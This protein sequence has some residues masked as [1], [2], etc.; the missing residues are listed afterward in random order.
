MNANNLESTRE[1]GGRASAVEATEA[2]HRPARVRRQPSRIR[3]LLFL[4]IPYL[5][6]VLVLVGVEVSTRFWLPHVSTLEAWVQSPEQSSTFSDRKQVRIFEG[7]PVLFWRLKPNLDHVI[8]DFTMVSTNAQGLR[9]EGPTGR[10]AA[11]AIRILCLG[12]SIT[13]GYRVPVVWP[14][15][16]KEYGHDWLP[17]PMLL[18]RRL[19]AANPGRQIE[20]IALAV[21]GYTSYQGLAWLRRDIEELKPDVVTACFGWNDV[22]MRAQTD[23]QTM[24]NGWAQVILRRAMARSQ[25][26]THAALWLQK[27]RG[28][29]PAPSATMPVPRV[30]DREYVNNLLEIARIT[31]EHNASAV[32]IG[33]VYRDRE[34]DPKEA[35]LMMHYGESLRAAAEEARVPYLEIRELTEAG[36]PDNVKLFGEPIHPNHEGHRRMADALLKFFAA[37]DMLKGINVPPSL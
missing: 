16:P 2:S 22:G 31:K 29:N 36:Y 34:H 24:H 8:W 9:H 15:R 18:E 1:T 17:Y 37:H 25:A 11:G 32:I 7:D 5:V 21:P 30:T 35:N 14:E 20:V 10:K 12:D 28:E 13:F 19:R 3:R 26:L 23:S 4:S 6:F 33:P 27:R